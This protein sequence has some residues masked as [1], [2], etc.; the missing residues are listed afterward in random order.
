MGM[1]DYVTCE[2]EL[3]DTPEAIQNDAFQTKSFGDGLTGGYMDDY[4]ITATG[5]LIYHK[6]LYEVVPE[7]E[8]PYYGK[9][10]WKNP[11]MQV[12]GAMKAV[13]QGDEII[14]HHGII[15]IYT[16]DHAGG[17]VWF[18]YEIKF[19]NGKVENVKRI[20]REFG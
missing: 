14:E 3:P 1:F 9:P 19:T 15:N 5:E 6:K 13:P 2:Y 7:E 18:E 10:E 12:C 8:R 16:I 17:G 11:L 20:Y 4:T